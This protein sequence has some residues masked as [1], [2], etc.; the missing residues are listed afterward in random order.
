M[1]KSLKNNTIKF[2]ALIAVCMFIIPSL[3][4]AD[5]PPPVPVNINSAACSGSDITITSNPGEHACD[6]VN[7]GGT[8]ANNLVS[9]IINVLSA[10]IGVVAVIMIIVAGFRY[11]SSGGSDEAVKGAKNTIVYAV[12]GLVVA[13]FAQIMVHFVLAKTTSAT[14]PKCVASGNAHKWDSGPNAGKACTP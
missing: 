3:A 4:Y 8:V 12:V 14:T 13:A 7:Q 6:N 5:D 2:I 11:V 1:L 10:L 9:E